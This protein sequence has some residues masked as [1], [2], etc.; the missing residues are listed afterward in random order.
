MHILW[1]VLIEHTSRS[2]SG[3]RT[4]DYFIVTLAQLLIVNSGRKQMDSNGLS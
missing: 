2:R 3:V 1:I 4:L